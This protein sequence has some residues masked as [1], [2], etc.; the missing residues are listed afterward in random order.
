MVCIRLR[1]RLVELMIPRLE[2]DTVA[3]GS[4]VDK[5]DIAKVS[6]QW[7]EYTDMVRPVVVVVDF[8]LH[9]LHNRRQ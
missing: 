1:H 6:K 7:L 8:H 3:Q 4:Q 2:Q 9:L 5:Q